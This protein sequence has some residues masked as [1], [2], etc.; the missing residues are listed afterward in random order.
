MLSI[1]WCMHHPPAYS[2]HQQPRAAARFALSGAQAGQPNNPPPVANNRPAIPPALRHL[3]VNEKIFLIFAPIPPAG[4]NTSP[5]R[6]V[7]TINGK[8]RLFAGK[9]ASFSVYPTIS[10]VLRAK[11]GNKL[12]PSGNN[13]PLERTKSKNFSAFFTAIDA[14]AA[15]RILFRVPN[16]LESA[17]FCRLAPAVS[18]YRFFQDE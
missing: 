16:R 18:V 14:D 6:L 1:S 11:S 4:R 3:F 7:R 9:L 2:F 5:G 12:V 17:A 15:R 10:S 8:A 13:V